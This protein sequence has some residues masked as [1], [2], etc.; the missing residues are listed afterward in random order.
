[1]IY[2]SPSILA[3]DFTTLGDQ[4]SAAKEG[5]ADMIH[6]DVM[7]GVFVPNIS[8]G[9]PV[10]KSLSARF[11]IPLDV[12]FMIVDPEKYIDAAADAGADGLTFHLEATDAP[13][14]LIKKIRDKGMHPSVSVKPNTPIEAAFPYIESLDMILIM[15]VEPG[16]GGQKIMPEPIEKVRRLR[17]ETDRLGL[18]D[19]KIEVDGGI[20]RKNIKELVDAGANVIVMGSAVFGESNI[21]TAIKELR[22]TAE[23]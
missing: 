9:F 16:F 6:V 18:P 21:P 2:I 23:A 11:S 12:H 5:G 14:R 19:F 8:I 7:D 10:I 22:A 13:E 3:C 15:T 17:A 1:M 20:G 4:V